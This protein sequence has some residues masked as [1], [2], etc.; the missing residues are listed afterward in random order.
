MNFSRY[1]TK[2]LAVRFFVP[3][4]IEALL[5]FLDFLGTLAHILCQQGEPGLVKILTVT[6][7]HDVPDPFLSEFPLPVEDYFR[8]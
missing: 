2:C 1:K 7:F 3:D 8:F 4:Q 5:I 6:C